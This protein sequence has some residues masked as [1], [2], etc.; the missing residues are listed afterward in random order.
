[1]GFDFALPGA[2]TAFD[3][4]ISSDIVLI[5]NTKNTSVCNTN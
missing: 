3:S 1:M 4:P 2:V 5:T